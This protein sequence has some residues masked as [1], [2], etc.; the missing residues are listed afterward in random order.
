MRL[1]KTEPPIACSFLKTDCDAILAAQSLSLHLAEDQV[2]I[3][4]TN[5][6]HLAQFAP[7]KLW[8]D[9]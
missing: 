8:R 1:T 4:T 2:V 5:V 6:G 9:I 7:A 3:A